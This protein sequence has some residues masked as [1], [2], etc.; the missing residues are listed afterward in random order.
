MCLQ[1]ELAQVVLE[2]KSR[3]LVSSVSDAIRQ[4]ILILSERVA[5]RDLVITRSQVMDKKQIED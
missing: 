1:G 2:L 5:Q 3:G 4:G